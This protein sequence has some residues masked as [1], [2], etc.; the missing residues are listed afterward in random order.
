MAAWQA[1]EHFWGSPIGV[2]LILGDYSKGCHKRLL[3]GLT[4]ALGLLGVRLYG[5]PHLHSD[6]CRVQALAIQAAK[7]RT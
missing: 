3:K 5:F 7:P 4:G 1:L 6:G 2:T